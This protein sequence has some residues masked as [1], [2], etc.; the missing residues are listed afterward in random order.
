MKCLIK[1][2]INEKHATGLCGKHYTQKRRTGNPEAF[3]HKLHN[4]S[5]RPEY[6][7]WNQMRQRCSN[8]N[9]PKYKNYGARGIKVCVEWKNSFVNFY[10]DMGERPLNTTLERIDNDGNYTPENCKWAT[11][12][13]QANN[14]RKRGVQILHYDVQ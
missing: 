2:C 6:Q 8:T 11:Y 1:N 3:S 12:K 14:R 10:N 7:V 4:L 5:S 13:E 9:H